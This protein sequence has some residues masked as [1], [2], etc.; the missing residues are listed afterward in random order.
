MSE[1]LSGY[2]VLLPCSSD[3]CWVVPQCCLGEIVTVP[4]DD[5]QPPARVS[6]RGEM[7]PVVDFGP[8]DSLPW[9]DH[10]AGAG[11]VAVILGQQDKGCR[12]FGVAV[13]GPTLGVS[14]LAEEEIEDLPEAVQDYSSAAFR[15]N[16]TVYQVPDLLAL[17][18]AIGA[19]N[20]QIQ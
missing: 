16:G 12:Y 3:R 18:L 7:V 5:N 15:M 2:C 14:R 6:W 17:Q 20:L 8:Q 10:R 4:T 19:G 1:E 13:R 9:R 11:L